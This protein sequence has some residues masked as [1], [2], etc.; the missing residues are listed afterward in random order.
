MR[1]GG[2]VASL[3][4]RRHSVAHTGCEALA[5]GAAGVI[6]VRKASL[7]TYITPLMIGQVNG[8][9]HFASVTAG[10]IRDT[11]HE[12]T[13]VSRNLKCSQTD[14]TAPSSQKRLNRHLLNELGQIRPHN[15][16]G[17][18]EFSCI[19]IYRPFYGRCRSDQRAHVRIRSMRERRA[20]SYPS[21]G[22]SGP[23]APRSMQR[24]R[25]GRPAWLDWRGHVGIRARPS[26]LPATRA[27]SR[28][29]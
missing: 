7:S 13:G 22:R 18:N 19:T 25:R 14:R 26:G 12:T 11:Q 23:A 6:R 8:T 21:N 9:G 15:P 17:R 24:F 16:L 3:D 27:R 10:T 20:L 5:I 29:W 2:I 1:G 28:H 4:H